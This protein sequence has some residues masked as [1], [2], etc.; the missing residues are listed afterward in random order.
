VT[1]L[2]DWAAD[3]DWRSLPGGMDTLL[4][5]VKAGMLRYEQL[6]DGSI[7]L[8]DVLLC[9]TYLDNEAHNRQLAEELVR[10]NEDGH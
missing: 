2:P 10:R 8:E 3:A 1:P 5:P 9:N 6:R 7:T 4:R